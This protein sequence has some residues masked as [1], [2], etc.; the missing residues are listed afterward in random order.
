MLNES[1][2]PQALS[3]TLCYQRH[4]DECVWV[5]RSLQFSIRNWTYIVRTQLSKRN[6]LRD[7]GSLGAFKTHAREYP[8]N[9]HF[10]WCPTASGQLH[11]CMQVTCRVWLF[12]TPCSLLRFHGAQAPLSMAYSRQEYWNL[13]PC[14]P[15]G[16]LPDPG[17]ESAF[18]ISPALAGSFFTTR[19]TWEALWS[20]EHL[21]LFLIAMEIITNSRDEHTDP[22]V[23]RLFFGIGWHLVNPTTL[24]PHRLAVQNRMTMK[25]WWK[26]SSFPILTSRGHSKYQGYE[27]KGRHSRKLMRS[28]W[29]GRGIYSFPRRLVQPTPS[30]PQVFEVCYLDSELS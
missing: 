21:L 15:L 17:I 2:L 1:T 3:F 25:P 20:L 11:A 26:K 12:V 30:H 19:A 10:S 5:H 14:P 7:V 13:L 9:T 27:R 6:T 8:D 16:D 29:S 23:A 24:K 22:I 4:K 28:V 18:L